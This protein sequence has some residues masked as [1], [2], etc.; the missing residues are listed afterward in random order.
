MEKITTLPNFGQ[1]PPKGRE[2]NFKRPRESNSDSMR[3]PKRHQ[4]LDEELRLTLGWQTPNNT[5]FQST[6]PSPPKEI[7]QNKLVQIMPDMAKPPTPI[8]PRTRFQSG[9]KEPSTT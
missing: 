7:P 4:F 3:T 2:F 5:P 1:S 8:K 9:T 6:L